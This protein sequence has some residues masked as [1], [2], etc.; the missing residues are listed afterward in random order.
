MKHL[1]ILILDKK[2]RGIDSVVNVFETHGMKST[3][4]H[5]DRKR[6]KKITVTI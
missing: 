4:C 2:Y 5:I 6:N 1:K 3:V